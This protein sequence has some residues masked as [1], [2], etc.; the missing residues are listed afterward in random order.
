MALINTAQPLEYQSKI[1][2]LVYGYTDITL[3]IS[4]AGQDGIQLPFYQISDINYT[5]SNDGRQE[6]GGTSPVPIG[7]TA[8]HLTFKGNFT[9]SFEEDELLM[10][11]LVGF[12]NGQAGVSRIPFDLSIAY[13]PVVGRNPATGETRFIKDILYGVLIND[14]D[15]SHSRTGGALMVKHNFVFNLFSRN[16]LSMI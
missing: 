9:I 5:W 13:G 15:N 11:T 1:N 2:G 6:L 14:G 3:V 4:P 10:Q 7:Y 8:G 12:A 16:G